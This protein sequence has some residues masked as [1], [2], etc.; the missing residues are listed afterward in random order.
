MSNDITILLTDDD[1]GHARLIE[2]YLR[3]ADVFN[4]LIHFDK[5]KKLIDFLYQKNED[6]NRIPGKQ[7]LLLLDIRMPGMDGIEV[8]RQ[9]KNDDTFKIMPVIMLT[10]TSTN[11]EMEECYRLGCNG[12][13]IKPIDFLDFQTKLNVIGQFVK[14][15]SCPSIH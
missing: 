8:L 14:N 11:K 2:R 6:N 9:I 15:L 3:K 13:I 5:G 7:Y 12:Y 1:H 10:T 4:Q